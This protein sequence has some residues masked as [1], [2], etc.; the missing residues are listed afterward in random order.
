MKISFRDYKK[1]F[2]RSFEPQRG[3]ITLLFILLL[4]GIGLQLIIPQIMSY[5]IDSARTDKGISVL[6]IA[7]LLLIGLTIV[8]QA[9]QL[10]ETYVGENVAWVATNALRQEL[11]LH[12]LKLDRSFHQERSSGE[13]IERIDGDV[14]TLAN[15]FSR[16]LVQISGNILLI[17][18]IVVV[19]LFENI[20]IGLSFTVFTLLALFALNH[21]RDYA[22]PYWVTAG[23][24]SAEFSGFLGERLNGVEDIRS[25]RA[26]AYVMHQFF[27]VMRNLLL[28]ERSAYVRARIMWP[29][30]IVLFAVGYTLVFILGLYLLTN[31]LISIGVLFL[32]F[33][34]MDIIRSPLEQVTLQMEDLQ[35]ANASIQRIQELMSMDS[36][37][38]DE[39]KAQLSNGNVSV[40]FKD[41]TFGYKNESKALNNLSFKLR[42]GKKLGILGRTGSGKTTITRLL[43]RL[44]DVN[45]GNIIIGNHDIRDISLVE[46]RKHVSVVTQ[47]VRLFGASVRDNITMFDSSVPDDKIIDALEE[48]GLGDWIHSLSNGLDTELA[49]ND[50]G[51]SAGQAQLLAFARVF[52]KDPKLV[53]LDEASS[54]LDVSTE[55]II[56]KAIKK[57][58]KDRT[59]IIIAHRLKTIQQVDEIMVIEN[60]HI[61]EYGEREKLEEDED[62]RFAQLQKA[63]LKAVLV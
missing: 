60:G 49:S 1:L 9:T 62:S 28:K 43:L 55:K 21:I 33:Y 18:G 20:W 14:T 15:F 36:S 13:M 11:A 3:R 8:K 48:I 16:F 10:C 53:I 39:G 31:D 47:D 17:L 50:N 5:Y 56:D 4:V 32:M 22:T 24:A 25:N 29:A 6:Q 51:L 37:I 42:P 58:L 23:Q 46:L 26:T 61:I 63:D 45:S 12:C 27:K 38:K 44:H 52:L 54:R 57:L 2:K 41:V 34:Y 19:L 40:E 30:T 59:A 7:A 35:K